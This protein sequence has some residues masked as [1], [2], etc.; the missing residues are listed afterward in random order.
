M[1][2]KLNA[3]VY[4]ISKRILD[5]E[6]DY[7]IVYDTSRSKFEVHNS[8]QLDSTYCLTLPYKELDARALDYVWKTRSKNVET[9]LKKIDDENNSLEST[10]RNRVLSDF[11]DVIERRLNENY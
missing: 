10:E 3:D 2:I 4:E 11:N 5:I 8:A 1:K 9:I 7:Y 6:K